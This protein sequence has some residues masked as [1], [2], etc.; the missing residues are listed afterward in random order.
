MKDALHALA[1]WLIQSAPNAAA[2]L[3]GLAM[4]GCV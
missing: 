2:L 4:K 3:F 1:C